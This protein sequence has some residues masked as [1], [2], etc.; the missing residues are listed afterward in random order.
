MRCRIL[1]GTLAAALLIA[2]SARGGTYTEAGITPDQCVGWATGWQ[3]YVVGEWTTPGWPTAVDAEWRHAERALG[4]ATAQHD[5]D[6]VSLGPSGSITLTFD[7]TIVNGDGADFAVYENGFWA[8]SFGGGFFAELAYVE[9]SSDG[10]AWARFPSVS[11]T[12]EPIGLSPAARQ[13]L[14]I[15][16][17]DVYNLAGKHPNN[18]YNAVVTCEGTPF[19]LSD[20]LAAASVLSGAVDLNDIHYVRIVDIIGNG[21]S[22]DSLGNPIYDGYPTAGSGGFDL[23][24][25]GVIHVASANPVPEPAS[26]MMFGTGL[27]AVGAVTR[28][29]R[30][31]SG[32]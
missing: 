7:A 15:D 24:A 18:S 25:V 3:N 30:G 19:D 2:A 23:E 29:A 21:G 14:P 28:R 1:T 10:L 4:P 16:P 6:V 32:R 13:N 9:V 31:R 12:E 20:L 26:V 27:A 22:L 8:T 11:L 5:Y 17:T